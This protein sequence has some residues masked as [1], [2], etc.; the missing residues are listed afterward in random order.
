MS[1]QGNDLPPNSGWQLPGP[2]FNLGSFRTQDSSAP[3]TRRGSMASN[4]HDLL[5]P[6]KAS[7][8]DDGETEARKRKRV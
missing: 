3:A 6:A 7:D 5:N 4:V 2:R 8:D 1:S